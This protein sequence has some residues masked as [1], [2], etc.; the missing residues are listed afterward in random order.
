MKI[1]VVI[2]DS[3]S[4]YC[5]KYDICQLAKLK[6][7]NLCWK[8]LERNK[9]YNIQIRDYLGVSWN[10]SFSCALEQY[11]HRIYSIP[12]IG[13]NIYCGARRYRQFSQREYLEAL[14]RFEKQ[15]ENSIKVQQR[16]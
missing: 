16:D 15:Y 6:N 10:Y 11:L 4:R 9:S 8:I 5:V 14:D 2:Y 12:I 13:R 3:K 1:K 7:G